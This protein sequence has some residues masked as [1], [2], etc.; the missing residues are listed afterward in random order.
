MLAG[1]DQLVSFTLASPLNIGILVERVVGHHR[2]FGHVVPRLVTVGRVPFGR[3]A[4]GS[5]KVR[6]DLRVN[7]HKL[8]RGTYLVTPRLLNRDGVVHELGTPRTVRIH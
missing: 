6:W 1:T 3:F 7:G 4:R 2:L 8:R 5:H